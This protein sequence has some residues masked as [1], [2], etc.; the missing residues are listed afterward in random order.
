MP[1]ATSRLDPGT[2]RRAF[3]HYPSGVAAIAATVDDEDQVFVAS[4]FTV[5]V[6]MEPPLVLFAAQHTSESWPR[7]RASSTLGVSILAAE[8][9]GLC[10]QLASKD[11]RS[12]WQ[13]VE[14]DRLPSGA[15]A[16]PGSSG[17]MECRIYSEQT[18][19]DHDVVVLEVLTLHVEP[20]VDPLVW[21]GSR[22]RTLD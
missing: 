12:R 19:G 21:H 4:S 8:Q 10:R 13:G 1:T 17:W 16:L 22:F 7:L 6:S 5:G 2:L 18:A 15:L 20:E 3:G 9:S 11:R 14:I